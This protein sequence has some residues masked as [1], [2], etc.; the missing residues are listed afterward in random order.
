MLTY[1]HLSDKKIHKKSDNGKKI[2]IFQY[3]IILTIF[4]EIAIHTFFRL[5]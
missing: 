1:A 5:F 4:V 2:Y 3:K